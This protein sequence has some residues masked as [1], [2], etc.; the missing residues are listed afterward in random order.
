MRIGATVLFGSGNAVQSYEWRVKR[1]LGQ[2]QGVIDSL[3]EYE[4]DEITAIR[5]VRSDDSSE[6]FQS[7]LN[8]IKQINCMTPLSFGGGV[9]SLGDLRL[10]S[11][12]PIERIVFSSAFLNYGHELVTEASRLFG[13]QAIQCLLPVRKV[14]NDIEIFN[15]S[16][17]RYQKPETR[18]MEFIDSSANEII[19][20]D[21]E[22]DG[23]TNKFN[24]HLIDQLGFRNEKIIAGGGVGPLTV[25]VAASLDLAA[26]HIDNKV[27]H[28][29]FSKGLYSNA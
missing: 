20:Y 25:G 22:S 9:R 15:S 14:G 7:D 6:D 17:S 19:V 13:R 24:F 26:V 10:I 11:K 12:A 5:P 27:L 4:I 2:L 28:R 18:I 1:S 8:A 16:K 3:E 23:M 21:L 29:E